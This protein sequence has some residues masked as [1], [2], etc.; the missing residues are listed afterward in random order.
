MVSELQRL[1]EN[2]GN[3]L[4]RSVAV[5]D[6]ALHLLAYNPHAGTIDTARTE[7]ILKRAVPREVVQYVYDCGAATAED[8]FTVPAR[9]DMSMDIARIGMPIRHRGALLGFI[10]LLASDGPVGDDHADAVRRSAE[11]VAMIMHREYLLGELSR[12]RERELTRDL[13]SGHAEVRTQAADQ[14]VSENLFSAGPALAL[15]VSLTRTGAPLTDSDRIALAA[16]VDFGRNRRP[17][18]TALTLERPDHAILLLAQHDAIER[19]AIKDLAGSIRER[20]LA[21]TETGGHCWVG[22]GEARAALSDVHHSYADARRAA[23]V[24]RIVHVL[25]TVVRYGELGVYGM[26]AELPADRLA[27]SLHPG[28]R[29]LFERHS[30]GDDALV[31]TIETFLDNAGHVK[32]TSDRLRIH[33]TS[34]YYRLR[35]IEEITGLDLSLGNDRLTLHLGLKM[36]RLI[37]IR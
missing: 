32:K 12:G 21:E 34:L 3:R 31:E 2:L 5:D 29:A 22:I 23:D 14:L 10:W 8:L 26:L 4:G 17:Q 16:G 35:R 13:I 6:P 19:Q 36:A 27:D 11:T 7:S 24:A 25:G 33:R 9:P 1:V 30:A 37:E 15:V 20:V 18:R 28:L